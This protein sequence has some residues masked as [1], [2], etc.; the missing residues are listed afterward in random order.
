MPS[1]MIPRAQQFAR[2]FFH[3][4]FRSNTFAVNLWSLTIASHQQSLSVKRNRYLHW[5]IFQDI[6]NAA[7]SWGKEDHSERIIALASKFSRVCSILPSVVEE[8]VHKEGEGAL[9]VAMAPASQPEKDSL[10]RELP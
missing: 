6:P 7:K 10:T 3:F 5:C 1:R 9:V 2:L 8:T 4:F